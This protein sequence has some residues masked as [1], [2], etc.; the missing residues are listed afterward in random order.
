MSAYEELQ[1]LFQ[2]AVDGQDPI[3]RDHLDTVRRA[4]AEGNAAALDAALGALA[5]FVTHS[6][7]AVKYAASRFGAQAIRLNECPRLRPMVLSTLIEKGLAAARTP[8]RGKTVEILL[9]FVAVDSAE[10]IV[11]T[12][13]GRAGQ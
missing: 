9:E 1:K 10:P 2:R 6:D 7:L 5:S 3:F 11:V 8:T 13:G 12:G 4:P